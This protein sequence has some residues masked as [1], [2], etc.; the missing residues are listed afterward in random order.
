MTELRCDCEPTIYDDRSVGHDQGCAVYPWCPHEV[1]AYACL[2]P[3][4]CSCAR[5]VALA[6]AHA[7]D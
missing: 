4:G 2:M 6:R 5:C 7:D 3:C 1:V